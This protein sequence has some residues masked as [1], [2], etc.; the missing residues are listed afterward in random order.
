MVKSS[1]ETCLVDVNLAAQ[2]RQTMS[3]IILNHFLNNFFY[4]SLSIESNRDHSEVYS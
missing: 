2:W 3:L 1:N 4:P